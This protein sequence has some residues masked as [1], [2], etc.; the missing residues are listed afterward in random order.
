MNKQLLKLP[1]KF[2]RESACPACK[3]RAYNVTVL[4][5]KQTPH[6]SGR[7]S[8]AV[9]CFPSCKQTKLLNCFKCNSRSFYLQHENKQFKK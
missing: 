9:F 5:T 1:G 6:E 4:G 8:D 7:E 2:A 3:P